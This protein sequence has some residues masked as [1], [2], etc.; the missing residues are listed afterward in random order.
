MI[1]FCVYKYIGKIAFMTTD[2]EQ[3][4]EWLNRNN[5]ECGEFGEVFGVEATRFIAVAPTLDKPPVLCKV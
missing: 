3:A 2:S 5:N 4:A 1:Y